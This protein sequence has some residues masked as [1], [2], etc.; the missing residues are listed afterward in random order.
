MATT[1]PENAQPET[2][3]VPQPFLPFAGDELLRVRVC[4]SDF[5][6]MVGVDKATVCRWIQKGTIT[7]GTDGRLDP[8]QAMREL[9]SRGDPDRIRARIVR[10]AFA[11]MADLR[12][13]ASRAGELEAQ[14]ATLKA[15]QNREARDY[16]RLEGWL[17]TFQDRLVA[18]PQAA[19]AKM[20]G[21]DW[22]VHV[23]E[24]LLAVMRA[25]YDIDDEIDVRA[26]VIA[27]AG[28]ADVG[29][30]EPGAHAVQEGGGGS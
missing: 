22:K 27:E 12:A 23:R 19:R 1:L 10:Q 8:Q 28:G 26:V 3:S 6:K 5:A 18:I 9:L 24:I 29:V 25:P 13:Q 30:L 21:L 7:L 4:Q 11:D 16:D 15:Q 17:N 14:V 2:T 20:D